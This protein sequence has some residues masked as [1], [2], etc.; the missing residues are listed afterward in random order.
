MCG[1]RTVKYLLRSQWK[2]SLTVISFHLMRM[3]PILPNCTLLV[4]RPGRLTYQ[5]KQPQADR[6]THNRDVFHQP[7]HAPGR[8]H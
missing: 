6:N 8:T 5:A 3:L 1:V 2:W 4:E 7:E